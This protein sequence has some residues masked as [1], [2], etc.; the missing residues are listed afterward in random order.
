MVHEKLMIAGWVAAQKVVRDHQKRKD[1]ELASGD[2][3]RKLNV[4]H[5]GTC[6]GTSKSCRQHERR[7][8]AS[9]VKL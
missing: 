3:N 8:S 9:M 6:S 1:N 7:A 5:S 2:T 4:T